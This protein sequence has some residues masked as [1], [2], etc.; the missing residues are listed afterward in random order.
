MNMN[1]QNN[2]TELNIRVKSGNLAAQGKGKVAITHMPDGQFRVEVL[3]PGEG[4]TPEPL[5]LTTV[6]RVE[7]VKTKTGWFGKGQW[8]KP[9]A[10]TIAGTI[11][12]PFGV[13]T[14]IALIK[15]GE[16][17][18]S[19][20]YALFLFGSSMGASYASGVYTGT[21]LTRVARFVV[22]TQ[23]GKHAVL[24]GPESVFRF[25]S[26]VYAAPNIQLEAVDSEAPSAPSGEPVPTPA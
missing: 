6:E 16:V 12:V 19:T 13:P 18:I 17:I 14:M 22:T 9:L 15:G 8:I 25:M 2:A 26:G 21:K 7:L 3:L 1:M 20:A 5:D 23:D 4:G 11:V 24:E 10:A